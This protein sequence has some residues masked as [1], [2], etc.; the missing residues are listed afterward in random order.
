MLATLLFFIMVFIVVALSVRERAGQLSAQARVFNGT[1][2]SSPLTS[3][4]AYL[5]GV[6]GGLYLSLSLIIDFLGVKVPVR[7]TLWGLE[8]DPLAAV[9]IVMATLQPFLLRLY[10]YF[11]RSRSIP[12]R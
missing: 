8:I 1:A 9:A 12:A 10:R 5:V 2:R 6:A 4:I 3:A 7:V 11:R